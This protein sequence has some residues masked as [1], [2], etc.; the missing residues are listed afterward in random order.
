MSLSET[1]SGG[2]AEDIESQ[3]EALQGD[4]A[5]DRLSLRETVVEIKESVNQVRSELVEHAAA[6]VQGQAQVQKSLEALSDKLKVRMKWAT[7]AKAIGTFTGGAL[8]VLVP[9]QSAKIADVLGKILAI[10]P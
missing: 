8:V 4:L 5:G 9:G 2:I 1:Q 10:I 6:A 7:V 3:I